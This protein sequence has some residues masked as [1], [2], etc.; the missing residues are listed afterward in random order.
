[1]FRDSQKEKWKENLMEIEKKRNEL[2]LKMQKRSQELQSLQDKK[3]NFFKEACACEEEMRKVSE[4]VEERKVRFVALSETTG[5]CRM[6]ADDLEDEIKGR[7]R[8]KRQLCVA[9]QWMMQTVRA[10]R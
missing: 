3:R 6:A 7:R 10:I 9:V 4:E 2:L 8:K 1:M 5:N